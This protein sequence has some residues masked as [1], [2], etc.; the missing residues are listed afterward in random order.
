MVES[1][2]EQAMMKSDEI[3]VIPFETED[4][5]T[6]ETYVGILYTTAH[7][8]T[9]N[10]ITALIDHNSQVVERVSTLTDVG[11]ECALSRTKHIVTS[12]LHEGASKPLGITTIVFEQ[13]TFDPNEKSYAVIRC[14]K[15]HHVRGSI[16][17]EKVFYGNDPWEYW[18]DDGEYEVELIGLTDDGQP[19]WAQ[20]FEISVEV[21]PQPGTALAPMDPPNPRF[22]DLAAWALCVVNN[23]ASGCT[24]A[25]TGCVFSNDPYL[26]CVE[27][28]CGNAATGAIVGCTVAE[29]V[30]GWD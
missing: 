10:R 1:E 4:P 18:T 16:Q 8:I 29:F 22:I 25:A 20:S 27:T 17:L 5:V 23:T 28:G 9:Y 12:V 13:P 21:Y 30:L 14:F 11:F 19:I 15:F 24:D 3:G 2:A 7:E 6:G 26:D